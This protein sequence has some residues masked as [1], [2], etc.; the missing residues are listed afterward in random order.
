MAKE[1]VYLCRGHGFGHAARALPVLSALRAR[2]PDVRVRVASGTTGLSY[3]RANGQPCDDLA[4]TDR[5]DH[6]APVVREVHR[7]LGRSG[8]DLALVVS[9]EL[10]YVPML[11]RRMG[12]PSLFLTCRL[13]SEKGSPRL[14][15]ALGRV[16]REIVIPDWAF[17]HRVPDFLADLVTFTGPIAPII[18]FDRSRARALVG[19]D[20]EEYLAVVSWGAPHPAKARLQRKMAA[21]VLD[22]WRRDRPAGGRLVVLADEGETAARLGVDTRVPGVEWPGF[23]ADAPAFHR[24]ADVVFASGGS[25]ALEL[26]RNRV[27]TVAFCSSGGSVVPRRLRALERCGLLALSEGLR[28]DGVDRLSGLVERATARGA[29]HRGCELRWGDPEQV[30]DMIVDAVDS[31]DATG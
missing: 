7:Y 11:C 1:V 22:L 18:P 15:H 31:V 29:P 21:S 28:P 9:D 17:A 14:D 16:G 5:L 2:R 3:L 19:A 10:A 24:A 12:L 13:G 6:S 26:A 27:P 30:V 23:R 20:P 4:W 8:D 25:T